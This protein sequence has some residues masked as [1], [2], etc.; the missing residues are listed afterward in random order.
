MF[1]VFCVS[2]ENNIRNINRRESL[3]ISQ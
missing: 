1:F 2:E 3:F